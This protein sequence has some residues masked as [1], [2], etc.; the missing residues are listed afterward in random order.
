MNFWTNNT[1]NR[2]II[3][4]SGNITF[5]I[6]APGGVVVA[7]ATG[8]LSISSGLPASAGSGIAN[9]TARWITPSTLGTGAF[10]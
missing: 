1:P 6:L 7:N 5:P 2:M 4:N 10:T 3:D 9:Y 8:Q